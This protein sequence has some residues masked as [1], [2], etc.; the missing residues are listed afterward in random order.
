MLGDTLQGGR[1]G[2]LGGGASARRT[3]CIRK[4]LPPPTRLRVAP[5][6]PTDQHRRVRK[7]REAAFFGPGWPRRLYYCLDLTRILLINVYAIEIQVYCYKRSKNSWVSTRTELRVK[8]SKIAHSH[9]RSRVLLTI[10]I[11]DTVPEAGSDG[12][13]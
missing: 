13:T 1:V 8:D 6:M 10:V 9:T 11:T 5:D 7:A 2:A 12:L 4:N 3:G